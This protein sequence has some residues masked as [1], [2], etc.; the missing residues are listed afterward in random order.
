[1]PDRRLSVTLRQAAPIPLDVDVTCDPGQVLAIFGPSGGGKTTILRSIAGLNRPEH[2]LVRSGSDTWTDSASNVF[3]P[4]HRRAV[5]LVFQEYALFPHLS[6]LDNV[7]M[8][9]GHRPRSERRRR[10]AELL[11]LVHL[12]ARMSNRPH[13]LSGGERQRVALARAIARDPS[14]L[15]LDEPF[16]AVDKA[17]RRHLQDEIDALRHTLDMPILLVTHDFDDAVRLATHMLVVEH[18][19]GVEYGALTQLTSR[20]DVPFLRQ[21]VGLGSVFDAVVAGVDADRGLAVLQFEGG[22]LLVPAQ[23]GIAGDSVRVRI[24]AREVILALHPPQGLSLHNVLEGSIAAIHAEPDSDLVIV[25][26]QIGAEFLLSEVTRDAVA[27]LQ[28]AAGRRVCALIKSVSI[29][30]RRSSRN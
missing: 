27:R 2:A 22:E 30:V 4:P 24:P 12:H 7:V 11:E 15:L 8:A 5:G 9:L 23:A 26:I 19:K 3:V 17:V 25:R 6:A 16:A 20:P 13:E 1:V 21:A 18:G 29:E 10:A 14:V 28:L